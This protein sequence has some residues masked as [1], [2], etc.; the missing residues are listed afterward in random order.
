[1]VSEDIETRA[2]ETGVKYLELIGCEILDEDY[3]G[4]VVAEDTDCVVFAGIDV[5]VGE[6]REFGDEDSK[7]L[8][9]EFERA[10]IEFFSECSVEPDVKVRL[11]KICVAVV[12]NSRAV[13]KHY[14]NVCNER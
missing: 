10:M 14:V 2:R 3:S 13:L 1:M 11:D 5:E 8:V 4:F 12:S 7:M 9:M 6:F